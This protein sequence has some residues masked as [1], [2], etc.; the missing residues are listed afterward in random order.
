MLSHLLL[1]LT[2]AL[3]SLLSLAIYRLHFHP[4][5]PLPGPTLA[6]ITKLW[7]IWH[8]RRG[9][10]HTLLPSLHTKYGPIVRI[11]P[12]QVLICSEE[13]IRLA[14]NAGTQFTK[15][16]WYRVAR[17]PRAPGEDGLDLLTEMDRG[18]YK[19]QRR[20]IGPAYSVKGMEKH[21][22]K[23]STYIETWI[24]ASR[25]QQKD[26]ADW[27]HIYAMDALSWF[28]LGKSWG[29][30]EKGYDGGNLE[31]S[32]SIWSVF[33]VLGMIPWYVDLMH[34]LPKVGGVLVLPASLALGLGMPK[35]W[36]LLEQVVPEIGRRLRGLES[37]A[38]V[39]M[40]DRLG[41][42]QKV[43]HDIP[44]NTGDGDGGSGKEEDLLASLMTL[45][46]SKSASFPPSWV[47]GISLT[48]FGAGHDTVMI[49]LAG[50]LY[51]LATHRQYI[52]QLRLDM[53]AQN[54]SKDAGYTELIT[55]I[56]LFPLLLKESLRLVPAVSFYLPR[57]VPAGGAT[58]SNYHIPAGTTIGCHLWATHRDANVFPDPH[59]FKPERWMQDGSDEKRRQI[60][61]MDHMYMGFGGQSR[62]CPGQNL[63]KIFV[64]KAVKRCVE[65]FD[66]E[67]EGNFEE[68]C[69]GWFATGL[70][71]V[72]IRF[73]PRSDL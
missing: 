26:L 45:H 55:K 29:Y 56:P 13:S 23:L 40:R 54:I 17:A 47:L 20:A 44:Q 3:T 65:E 30:T 53:A 50:L 7:L 71:G 52:T 18:K 67:V 31:A 5:S 48:N 38:G 63:G 12:S 11:T 60:S 73:M 28:V 27:T 70:R 68:G 1:A 58:I 14:Y 39:E 42:I 37:T 22:S 41:V 59:A 10:S 62:S 36:P 16:S 46:S 15:G 61:R 69:V 51:Q 25:G 32:E 19:K 6:R 24:S 8:I 57:I 49:T 43:E 4:L 72:G 66:M 2:L 35:M 33:T 64:I 21:E 9:T 34:W